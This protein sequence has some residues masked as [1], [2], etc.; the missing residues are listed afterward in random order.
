MGWIRKK[1]ESLAGTFVAVVSGL[2]ALQMPAFIDAYL[3]R[4]G[5]HLDQARL[6]LVAIKTG[7]AGQMAGGAAMH[8]QLV[9][10]A[11]ARV[12]YLEAAQAAITNASQL[13][14]PFAF[15]MHL[16]GDIAVAAAQSYTP[17]LPLD[18][19]SLVYAVVGIVLG[20]L[21][22]GAVKAP[23]RLFRRIRRH[24]EKT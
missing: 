3:Q 11:Q 9:S 13:E 21:I 6:G 17:A 24:A 1:L 10:A 4:L 2:T 19:P 14:K 22:W 15:F 7:A 20:W 16:D 23:A 12:D 5:G 8:D 18:V